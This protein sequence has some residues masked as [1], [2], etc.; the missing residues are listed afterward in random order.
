MPRPHLRSLLHR[1]RD[2]APEIGGTKPTNPPPKIQKPDAPLDGDQQTGTSI[3]RPVMALFYRLLAEDR[4]EAALPPAALHPE[5]ADGYPLHFA[6]TRRQ[7]HIISQLLEAHA[8]PN[9]PYPSQ[10]F[11]APLL[12]A[13]QHYHS[14]C[15]P[16][17]KLLIEHGASFET[18][19]ERIPQHERA[20]V[21]S[22][23]VSTVDSDPTLEFLL[24]NCINIGDKWHN[25]FP[26]AL[27]YA[28]AFWRPNSIR[29]LVQYGAVPTAKSYQILGA[30]FRFPKIH[31]IEEFNQRAPLECGSVAGE[32]SALHLAIKFPSE[33]LCVALINQGSP[34][35]SKDYYGVTP[36]LDAIFYGHCGA[37]VCLLR[38]GA[39]PNPTPLVCPGW[40][41]PYRYGDPTF[42]ICIELGFSSLH[43]AVHQGYANI[44]LLLLEFGCEK[45]PLDARGRTP[46]D[47]AIENRNYS[48]SYHM[49]REGCAFRT[50]NEV[51]Q[52][53][54]QAVKN[55]DD[56]II[57]RLLLSDIGLPTIDDKLDSNS[58]KGI[59]S[60]NPGA[61]L[62]TQNQWRPK[63]EPRICVQCALIALPDLRMRWERSRDILHILPSDCQFCHLAEDSMPENGAPTTL[64]VLSICPYRKQSTELCLY[65]RYTGTTR[66]SI[67]SLDGEWSS[68]LSIVNGLED[69]ETSSPAATAMAGRWLERCMNEHDQCTPEMMTD[70]TPSR[71][72]DIGPPGSSQ[73]PRI[74]EQP[75]QSAPYV[76][77]SHRWGSVGLPQTTMGNLSERKIGIGNS[78]LS[79]TMLDAI[80]LVRQLGFQYLWVDALCIL[81]DSSEDWMRE[82]AMMGNV[83]RSAILTLAAAASEDHSQGI[84]KPREARCL[85]PF[86][87]PTIDH[88]HGGT[89]SSS[90][91]NGD[92]Y[93][94]PRSRRVSQ[95][96]RPKGPLDTRGWVLQEQLLSPRILYYGCGELFW[97]CITTSAAESS[98]ISSSL[99]IDENPAETW[100]L[101][102][103]R[104][105]IAGASDAEALN[106]H[107]GDAWM[108]V[109]MNYSAR[110]LTKQS[111]KLIAI[112]GILSA[113]SEVLD[114]VFVAGMWRR[115]LWRQLIWW[116]KYTHN[117]DSE[118]LEKKVVVPSWSWLRSDGP[119]YFGNGIDR[120]K[121][122]DFEELAPSTNIL[123][124]AVTTITQGMELQGTLIVR[125]D[126]FSY[127]LTQN[128][129]KDLGW[130]RW[131]QKKLRLAKAQWWLDESLEFPLEVHCIVMAEDV[132]AKVTVCICVVPVGN[133]D[134]IFRRVGLCHWEGLTHDIP[135]HTG[136]E[137]IKRKITLI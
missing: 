30:G 130:K 115:R 27:G 125:G 86:Q 47:I 8:D 126:T 18:S 60:L 107:A 42:D 87:F 40:Q 61:F 6:I 102:L 54:A 97:D 14:H 4:N 105:T 120:K 110:K 114:D 73:V 24:S 104:R 56:K 17:L 74:V 124:V 28:M 118:S 51:G 7:T 66:H 5:Y 46:L 63:T 67:E 131:D 38:S 84:F 10:V 16:I 2:G 88:I 64:K 21:T 48:L 128:D 77:L 35:D 101:K 19:M 33:D 111:D 31:T 45:S 85:R 92:L 39:N 26:S 49:I 52:Y 44:A 94:F 1:G 79:R 112:E 89:D 109:V 119:V 127:R 62:A 32:P 136:Q 129:L 78:Q 57:H 100:A 103:I 90:T 12:D 82:S 117:I 58:A 9:A 41:G 43:V 70:F 135:R 122:P 108:Q 13:V 37:V 50:K 93:V 23:L 53:L 134:Q 121:T 15:I 76:A 71:L 25:W 69:S 22:P 29:I 106:K 80:S 68:F 59:T 81:Q 36:L 123:D 137:L 98:P 96:I 34:V 91:K 65:Q 20:G 11:H 99:L 95:G 75:Y 133:H 113:L 3:Y 72:L 116:T 83:Y 55:N 132:V